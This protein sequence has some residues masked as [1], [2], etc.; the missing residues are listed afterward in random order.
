M[1]CYFNVLWMI[2]HVYMPVPYIAEDLSNFKCSKTVLFMFRWTM[3]VTAIIVLWRILIKS[4]FIRYINVSLSS[5]EYYGT[6]RTMHGL[7]MLYTACEFIFNNTDLPRLIINCGTM[8]VKCDLC[9][10]T[11]NILD[12]ALH[13]MILLLL[14]I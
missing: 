8:K 5:N 4:N 7:I 14:L 10:S 12:Y 9:T 3:H 13:Y 6:M 11:N 2:L 1:F